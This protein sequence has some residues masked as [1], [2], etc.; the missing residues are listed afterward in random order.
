MRV[1]LDIDGTVTAMPEVFRTMSHA[2][3]ADHHHVYIVTAAMPDRNHPE[4]NTLAGRQRELET[5]GMKP[6]V[7]YDQIVLA[8]GEY[9]RQVAEAKARICKEMRLDLMIDNDPLNVAACREVTNV[10]VPSDD[11]PVYR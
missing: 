5:Y 4:K 11:P 9:R 3:M 1:G 2:L 7:N 10:L 6:G 8:W